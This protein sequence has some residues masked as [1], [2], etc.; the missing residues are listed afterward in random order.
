MPASSAPICEPLCL[1]KTYAPA[2]GLVIS[3][4][5]LEQPA[6]PLMTAVHFYWMI[7]MYAPS[8]ELGAESGR[9]I[10]ISSICACVQ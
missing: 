8:H 10:I 9:A 3:M 6:K 5:E 7:E 1:K 2:C 4:M